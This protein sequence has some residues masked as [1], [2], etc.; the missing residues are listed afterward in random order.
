[1]RN[2]SWH[3]GGPHSGAQIWASFGWLLIQG[4]R[5]TCTKRHSCLHARTLLGHPTEGTERISKSP[6]SS[7]GTA[8]VD[9]L[10]RGV[11]PRRVLLVVLDWHVQLALQEEP[12]GLGVNQSQ[13]SYSYP[14][15]VTFTQ[16]NFWHR[17]HI[18][19]KLG[20]T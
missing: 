20:Y 1:M 4:I 6:N 13:V 19:N 9:G 8:G 18:P 12:K 2:T 7:I 15:L 14:M 11:A 17:A 10:H 5:L 16:A 3:S